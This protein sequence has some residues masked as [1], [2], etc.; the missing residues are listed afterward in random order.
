MRTELD[1][2]VLGREPMEVGVFDDVIQRQEPTEIDGGI[3]ESPVA[4]V[5]NLQRPVDA[6]VGDPADSRA[7]LGTDD[8]NGLF[9]GKSPGHEALNEARRAEG[10][11]VEIGGVLS[12]GE[13][14]AV[15]AD[16]RDPLGVFL[17]PSERFKVFFPATLM[18][19]HGVSIC[20][21]T[22]LLNSTSNF[23]RIF[24]IGVELPGPAVRKSAHVMHCGN[25]G[26]APLP[27]RFHSAGGGRS[28]PSSG[29]TA[30]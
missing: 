17:A 12:A 11:R 23:R 9:H 29:G 22:R 30:G 5:G 6:L 27:H 28:H 20:S 15:E 1:L 26:N 21:T 4:D 3:G 8:G 14:A 18:S 19:N 7:V 24:P 2:L 10:V 16:H 13:H 25:R